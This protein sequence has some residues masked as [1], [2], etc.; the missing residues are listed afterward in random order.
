MLSVILSD[1]TFHTDVLHVL[2]KNVKWTFM[3]S[4]NLIFEHVQFGHHIAQYPI[5][6][7]KIFFLNSKY[8]T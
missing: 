8:L 3:Q 6:S 5:I 1:K 2:Q 7:S 4:Y